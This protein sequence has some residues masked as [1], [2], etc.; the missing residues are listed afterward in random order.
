MRM[1]F[2]GIHLEVFELDGSEAGTREHALDGVFEHHGRPAAQVPGWGFETLAAG[3]TRVANVD[4]VGHL[5]T[6][7]AH[8]FGVD[9]DHVVPAIDVGSE[10]GLVLS[11]QD[12][13][14]LRGEAAQD[15]SVR[16][17]DIPLFLGGSRIDGD[18]FV[19]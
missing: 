9:H 6:R 2:A 7:E 13:C 16:V 15:L 17:D 14:D 12:L 19:A 11:A 10:V 18:C 1:H 8:F 4:L 3:I 5:L